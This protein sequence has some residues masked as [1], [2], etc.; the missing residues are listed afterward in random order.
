ML[1]L[2]LKICTFSSLSEYI[3]PLFKL[4]NIY[5]YKQIPNLFSVWRLWLAN[6]LKRRRKIRLLYDFVFLPWFGFIFSR[7][8][9]C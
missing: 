1:S 2:V 8:D 4:L 5:I 6:W 7:L 3:L 9:Y